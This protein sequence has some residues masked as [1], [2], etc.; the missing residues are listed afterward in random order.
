MDSIKSQEDDGKKKIE[1]IDIFKMEGAPAEWNRYPLLRDSQP[2][3]YF[4]LKLS[5]YE[6]GIED[7]LCAVA[8][9]SWNVHGFGGA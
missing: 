3:R 4:E 8:S 1:Y 9:A 5:I 2:D 7:P 6:K